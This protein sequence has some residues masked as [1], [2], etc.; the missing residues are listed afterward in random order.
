[1][2]QP[3]PRTEGMERVDP[4]SELRDLKRAIDEH[5]I[6]AVTDAKGRITSVNEKF[7]AISKYSR[8]ELLGQ[9]HRILS[10][11]FHPNEFFRT[12][13]L[14]IRSG[15]VWRG[16]I[17]NRAKDGSLYWVSTTIV[18]FMDE[19]GSPWQ[20]VAIRTD[21]TERKVAEMA[22]KESE[23]RWRTIV[24]SEPECVKI[25]DGGCRLLDMNP[26]GLR[27]IAA[28]SLQEVRGTN[29]LDL[30]HPR[31]RNSFRD[32]VGQVL[33]GES[34]HQ[35]FEIVALDGQHRWMEQRAVPLWD[36]K[37]PG[38]V[39]QV[40]AVTRDITDRKRAEDK[41][42]EQAKL[43]DE[44][45][46]SIIVRD[47][48]GIIRL[49]NHGAETTF[50]WSAAETLG[51]STEELGICDP[52]A[53]VLAM[54]M[55]KEQ[56]VWAGELR[57]NTKDG[58]ALILES[59]WTLLLDGGGSP[60]SI[61]SISLDVTRQRRIEAQLLRSE[62]MQTLGTLSAGIAHDMNN[63]LAPI[64]VGLPLLR[65]EA[66]TPETRELLDLM[67]VSVLR[68]ADIVKQLLLFGRGGESARVPMNP[69]RQLREVER[70]VLE[71]FPKNVVLRTHYSED[72]GSI[73]GD[74]TQVYQVLLNLVVNARDAM[75]QGGI[76][77]LSA[78]NVRIG[79]V[80]VR[81]HPTGRAGSFVLMSVAD[82]GSGMDQRIL[83]R[84][85]EPFFT[86]KDTG[87]GTG[88][89]LPVALGVVESHDGFI[90]V[91][92]EIGRGTTFRVHLPIHETGDLKPST[93]PPPPL[94]RGRGECV[95]V[96]DDEKALLKVAGKILE[97]QGYRVLLAEDAAQARKLFSIHAGEIPVVISDLS[98]P[99]MTGLELV[100]ILR[101]ERPNTRFAISSGLG[102][103]LDPEKLRVD[104]VELILNK[105]YT[106]E[107]LLGSV[108]QLIGDRS[109][110]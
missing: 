42:F 75:P 57:A 63:I 11:G 58:R 92:S 83:D 98:M 51:R 67:Q 88:L 24:E 15:S 18:P 32:G 19:T 28:G 9:D 52:D 40:L 108:Q 17:K 21:I 80:P 109:G 74:P 110:G 23:A 47:L 43:I 27:M 54:N 73:Q 6:V 76:L 33:R 72:L 89:G 8:E 39:R 26:A 62:R 45:S 5:S 38:H 94:P 102:G 3:V 100:R 44:A 4:L 66:R 12:L 20:Y 50:G 22:L 77:T 86:T 36:Q 103:T 1:M 84:I 49:W 56:G 29:V 14:T 99:G 35:I 7:C 104:G 37:D 96:V 46:D 31:H 10:S 41:I 34:T 101:R 69:L 107:V 30:V 105:P 48:E 60:H 70:I 68:G 53:F 106:P 97:Q 91:Q 82:T 61:L 55:V 95:L 85:F 78:E 2:P 87:K 71:T 79:E 64:L 13:W 25:L 90:T 16:E 65:E 93:P 59:R 81:S